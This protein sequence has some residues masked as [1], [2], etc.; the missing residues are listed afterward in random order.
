MSKRDFYPYNCVKQRDMM[1]PTECTYPQKLCFGGYKFPVFLELA[2]MRTFH[3][4]QI[5]L[6]KTALSH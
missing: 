5:K 3:G 1:T 4:K 6:S 2:E